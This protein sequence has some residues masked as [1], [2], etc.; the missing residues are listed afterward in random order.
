MRKTLI[1]ILFLLLPHTVSAELFMNKPLHEDINF[2][3]ISFPE[4]NEIKELLGDNPSNLNIVMIYI[5]SLIFN[6][7]KVSKEQQYTLQET[8]D[9]LPSAK[10]VRINEIIEKQLARCN[11]KFMIIDLSGGDHYLPLKII[12]ANE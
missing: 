7:G 8:L 9:N 2:S 5:K 3:K 1:L 12:K 4:E 6:N 10:K 11:C